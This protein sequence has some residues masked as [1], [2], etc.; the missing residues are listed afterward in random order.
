VPLAALHLMKSCRY[1]RLRSSA[2]GLDGGLKEGLHPILR[3]EKR[4]SVL[5]PTQPPPIGMPVSERPE[6]I[7][8][9]FLA[10]SIP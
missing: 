6:M 9:A 3:P 1:C 5:F 10:H 7:E 8:F 2:E 4:Q